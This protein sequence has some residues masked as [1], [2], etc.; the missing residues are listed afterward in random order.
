[1]ARSKRSTKGLVYQLKVTLA[2]IRPPIW[3][4]IQVP[5]STLLPRLHLMLQ[6]AMG[7]TNCHLHQ[8]TI[9]GVDYGTPDPD[10]ELEIEN[11]ARVRLDKAIPATGVRFTY[12][13]DFGDGW[14]HKI[15]VEKIVPPDPEV[16]YPACLAGARACPPED[17]GGVW[18]YGDFLEAIG[19]ADH[20]DHEQLLEWV[21]GSFDPETFDLNGVNGRLKN[22]KLLSPLDD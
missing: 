17:C 9:D 13:Y 1:M 22:Y 6:A 7:W 19:D 10:F 5:G 2:E 8:F 16:S 18:G 14:S 11:E 4:R 21:G 15:L 12:L 20:E 3:R